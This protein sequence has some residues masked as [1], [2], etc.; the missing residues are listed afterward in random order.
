MSSLRPWHE[1]LSWRNPN[2]FACVAVECCMYLAIIYSRLE[3]AAV[4]YSARSCMSPSVLGNIA[5]KSSRSAKHRQAT[6]T[7]EIAKKY[8]IRQ[9]TLLGVSPVSGDLDLHMR[10][11]SL[12]V[13]P[14]PGPRLLLAT[15]QRRVDAHR[16][17]T[18]KEC[19]GRRKGSRK[20]WHTSSFPMGGPYGENHEDCAYARVRNVQGYPHSCLSSR[21]TIPHLIH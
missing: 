8:S 20:A 15:E 2:M 16:V 14:P 1:P 17:L 13:S 10:L 12:G 9:C 18:T 6:S 3:R 7:D 21:C 4:Q 19:A 11:C 5:R